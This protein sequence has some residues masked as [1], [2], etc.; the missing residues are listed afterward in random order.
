MG[1][2]HKCKGEGC[3]NYVKMPP[4]RPMATGYCK[5]CYHSTGLHREKSTRNHGPDGRFTR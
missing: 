1:G 2:I 4:N 3:M 5:K